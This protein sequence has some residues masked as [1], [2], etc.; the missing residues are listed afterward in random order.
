MVLRNFK[1]PLNIV[2]DL[3]Y[4]ERVVLYIETT[5]FIPED[6]ELTSLFI[7]FQDIV[8]NRL[9]PTYKTHI[10]SHI[11]LPGLLARINTDVDRLL[12]GSVLQTSDFIRNIMSTTKV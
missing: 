8:R 5:Q 12:I 9:C 6:T 3:Q 2:S 1:A 11:G 7:Q 4:V 10:H